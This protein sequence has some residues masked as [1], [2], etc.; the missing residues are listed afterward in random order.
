MVTTTLRR[1]I[2]G[3]IVGCGSGLCCV[4]LC[5]DYCDVQLHFV[6]A[7]MY[8]HCLLHHLS[9]A[10]SRETTSCSFSLKGRKE[11]KDE[12]ESLTTIAAIFT[13]TSEW[14]VLVHHHSD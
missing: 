10:S 12:K 14:G 13:E 3:S 11:E 9:T 1:E 6:Y 5:E 8:T 4:R 7:Q 2:N